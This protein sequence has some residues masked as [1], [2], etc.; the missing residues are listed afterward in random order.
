M[1]IVFQSL[2]NNTGTDYRRRRAPD[3]QGGWSIDY[4]D[5]GA[6]NCRIRPA[7]SAEREVAMSEERQITHVLY[8]E[9]GTDILRGDRYLVDGLLVEVDAIREPS[10]ANEHLEIDCLERQQEDGEPISLDAWEMIGG[11][12]WELIDGRTWEAVT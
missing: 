2:L 8:V 9:Y 1:G 6:S 5:N 10:K 7:S 3:G 11:I 4:V 12:D